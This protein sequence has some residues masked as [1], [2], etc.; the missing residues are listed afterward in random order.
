M[1][2][3][4]ITLV[5]DGE[6]PFCHNYSQMVRLKENVGNLKLINAREAQPEVEEIKNKGFD[7]NEGMV[8]KIDTQYYHGAEALNVLALLS[9]RSGFFNRLNYWFFRSTKL[10]K[11]AYPFLRGGR[12]L[13]LKLMGRSK[14]AP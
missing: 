7:L 1:S 8:V 9:S 14:I 11:I 4:I 6:C 2:N 12:N 10:S 5:Y 3:K 13:A